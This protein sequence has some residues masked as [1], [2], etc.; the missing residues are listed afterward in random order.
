MDNSPK[1]DPAQPETGSR[2]LSP[3]VTVVILNWNRREDTLACLDSVVQSHYPRLAA[4][5]VD[6]GSTD[7]SV[8]AIAERFPQVEQIRLAENKGFAVGMNAGLRRALESGTDQTLVLNNDTIVDSNCIATL[9]NY[10]AVEYGILAPL[11]YSFFQPDIIWA[12]GGQTRSILLERQDPWAGK[13]DPG[14]WPEKIDQDFVTGC[15]MLLS[16]RFLTT[17]GMFDEQ[18]RLYY[19]DSD[20]CLRARTAGF[21]I[22]MIPAA[23][24][25]HKVATS[26]GGGDSPNERYWMAR[27]SVRFFVKHAHGIQI[28]AILFWRLGSAVRTSWRL[29]RSNNWEAFK[30]Y[31]RGLWH[32]IQDRKEAQP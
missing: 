20:L 11:I 14:Q 6:N 12:A 31:W 2:D 28:P 7:G 13:P 1:Q 15:A 4:I 10:A 32:G 3:L 23:K 16:R 21:K 27:S 19:E 18:F 29:A 8:E 5:V 26:S 17:A 24:I 25:W 30:A 22:A 9:V